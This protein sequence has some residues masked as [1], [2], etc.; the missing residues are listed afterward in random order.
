[1]S[2]ARYPSDQD[3]ESGR[4]ADRPL[5]KALHQAKV[6]GATVVIAKLERGP[7]DPNLSAARLGG[8]LLSPMIPRPQ[9]LGG[10]DST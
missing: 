1:M 10:L 6:T 2:G 4:H 9:N 7:N 3:V 5:A 8:H